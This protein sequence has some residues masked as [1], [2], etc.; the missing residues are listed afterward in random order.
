[1]DARA[2]LQN[3]DREP[4]FRV[5]LQRRA[6]A[7]HPAAVTDD[8]ASADV[9]DGQPVT[10]R[11]RLVHVRARKAHL[12]DRVVAAENYSS[13]GA[14]VVRRRRDRPVRLRRLEPRGGRQRRFWIAEPVVVQVLVADRQACAELMRDRRLGRR[15]AERVEDPRSDHVPVRAFLQRFEHQPER[16]VADVRVVEARARRRPRYEVA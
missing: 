5:C 7:D 12:R 15:H 8:A 9:T 14:H 10:V 4:C 2:V 3:N 13:E 1:V 16:L 11:R 6:I